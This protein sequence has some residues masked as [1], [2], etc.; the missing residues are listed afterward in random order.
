MLRT[1]AAKR[2]VV[3]FS[4]K[5]VIALSLRRNNDFKMGYDGLPS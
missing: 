2:L 4:A 3:G 5:I 1:T